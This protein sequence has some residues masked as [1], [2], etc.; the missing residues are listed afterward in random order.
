MS[1]LGFFYFPI[2]IASALL[3][4]CSSNFRLESVQHL[5]RNDMFER[6]K[7]WHHAI[8]IHHLYLFYVTLI[9]LL[10]SQ[11]WNSTD[12]G[13]HWQIK[14]TILSLSKFQANQLPSLKLL[15][16]PYLMFHLVVILILS[17]NL[18]LSENCRPYFNLCSDGVINKPKSP[19]KTLVAFT[20]FSQIRSIKSPTK[21]GI[22]PNQL[23]QQS[24][25]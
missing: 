1:T 11:Q 8:T 20:N 2:N 4:R 15:V 18:K 17:S 5:C 9:F 24:N 21:T 3:P 16:R 12:I 25:H 6:D 7:P 23:S 13:F 19:H 14:M 10:Q 22:S